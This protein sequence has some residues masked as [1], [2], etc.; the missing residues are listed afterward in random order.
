VSKED[1]IESL[2]YAGSALS[3][4]AGSQHAEAM[5]AANHVKDIKANLP[6]EELDK[7]VEALEA[8]LRAAGIVQSAPAGAPAGAPK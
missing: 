1:I 2:N 4:M 3:V 5:K 7:R 6:D 8:A